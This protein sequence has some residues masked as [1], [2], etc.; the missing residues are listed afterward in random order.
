MGDRALL[1]ALQGVVG[2]IVQP[3]MARKL[4]EV[5]PAS[6]REYN[7]PLDPM[8]LILAE[9]L[10]VSYG[11][12]DVLEGVSIAVPHQARI[13][14]VGPN[15]IGKSSLL[16]VLAGVERPSGG[17]LQKARGL[18]IGYL[19]QTSAGAAEMG[20]GG[21]IELYELALGAFKRL[22]EMEDKLV[23]LETRMSDPRAA[24]AAMTKYGPLQET[25]EREGGY[26]YHATA[27]R[28]LRG[29]G[30]DDHQFDQPL[31]TLSGGER[32][33]AQLARLLLQDPDVLLLD[34]PTNHLDIAGMEWLEGWLKSWPGALV[35]VSHDRAFLDAVVDRVV[36]VGRTELEEF[37]GDYSSYASQREDRLDRRRAVMERQKQHIEKEREYIRRN[38]AGQNSRQA[39]GRRTRLNRFL[40]ES[41]ISESRVARG[42]HVSLKSGRQSGRIIVACENLTL[43]DPADGGPLISLPDVK[44]GRG[45]CVAVIGPNGAGKTTLAR[46]IMGKFEPKRG[47]VELGV[48]ASIGYF[49][50]NL[51]AAPDAQ[52][53]LEALL[54]A[55]S[56]LL[57][58]DA[59]D[60]IARYGFQGDDVQKSVMH[61]SGGERARLELAKL[62]LAGANLLL[63]DEPT[64][65]L[66]LDSQ[67]A[68]QS[69]L[70]EY[71]GTILL[72][73]HDRYLIRRM[74][75]QIWAFEPDHSMI[76]VVRGG[77]GAY[78]EQLESEREVEDDTATRKREPRVP[79]GGSGAGNPALTVQIDT[80]EAR[81]SELESQL[82]RLSHQIESSRDDPEQAV[83]LGS[84]YAALQDELERWLERWERL[85]SQKNGT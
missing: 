79:P 60:H 55:D 73:S 18:E 78:L 13:A 58:S 26:S 38:I 82:E 42:I 23:E 19:P 49:P 63:L 32:T 53:V 74:A 50:Q 11:A 10:H 41:A 56:S 27:D 76:R 44:V 16:K 64:H 59:R 45:E 80:A 61:L 70:E 68:L 25:F 52:T 36:E 12:Q 6:W 37:R 20:V 48:K 8:S 43:A 17:A 65:H 4:A 21:E 28:V 84:R 57:L 47:S 31:N 7:P 2:I 69:A 15:G 62:T 54:E 85:E 29:L 5:L 67:E 77:Y 46:T 72:I 33:R 66:D 1:Y 81:V 75:T 71:D 14:L 24:E 22:R 40:K 3:G 9:D 30:F 34:E 51:P 83:A 35:V 39:K